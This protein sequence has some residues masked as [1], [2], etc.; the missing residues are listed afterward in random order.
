MNKHL[1]YIV[2]MCF[3]VLYTSVGFANPMNKTIVVND[4][5]KD[6]LTNQMAIIDEYE[7][8]LPAE[9]VREYI[10]SNVDLD[11]QLKQMKINFSLPRIRLAEPEL[12]QKFFSGTTFSLPT[13]NIDGISYVDLEVASKIFG[14]TTTMDAEKVTIAINQYSSFAPLLLKATA[15]RP[16]I[17]G[18]KINLV[19]QPTF[20]EKTDA[21][22]ADKIKGL[23]VVSPSWF[24]IID[25]HGTIKNKVDERYVKAAHA[26]GYQV[27]AL[28]TNSFDPDLTRKVLYNEYAKQ[29]VIK[30]LALYARL[31]QLDGINLDFENI[32]DADKDQLTQFVKEVTDTLHALDLKVSIDVTVPSGISQWSACYDRS[33]L[34]KNVDYVMLMA[35]D[36]HWRT[37]PVSGSVASIGWVERSLV[38]TL[39][40]V[41]AEKLV[42]G[43]PFYMRE[44]E[45]NLDGEKTGVKTMTMEMAEKTI[46][47]RQLKPEWLEAQGQYYFEY[48]DGDKRYRVWQEEERSMTLRVKLIDQYHLAGIAAWRKGFEGNEIWQV[49][50]SGLNE[51]KVTEKIVATQADQDKKETK[52]KKKNKKKSDTAK[53]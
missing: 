37:S 33:G 41:P 25:E 21:T 13:K 43:V 26:K 11:R 12:S 28:I 18:Q 17:T 4:G 19:W 39:K 44:W 36:E 7:I 10:Y 27:W 9:V 40:D 6:I 14:F 15:D 2:M 20:G 35:Y 49:I 46:R 31:Y 38:N 30:Q 34:A 32:Y 45:E 50:D 29:N 5:E 23:N 51:N 24:E 47:E 52:A 42:L 1:I 8:L 3:M 16:V 53:K 48:I 22:K